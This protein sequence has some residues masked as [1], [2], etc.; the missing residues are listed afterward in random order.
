VL[1]HLL[2]A[3]RTLA[4]VLAPFM[5]E[6][7]IALRNLLAVSDDSLQ[8]SWGQGLVAGHQINPPKVLF[9]RIEI[10]AKK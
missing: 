3:V 10:D 4:R 5:P 6:T 1:H 2:E 8:A 9:P 7:A